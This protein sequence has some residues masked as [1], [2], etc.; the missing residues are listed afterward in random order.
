MDDLKDLDSVAEHFGFLHL[1]H[2]KD[3]YYSGQLPDGRFQKIELNPVGHPHTNEGPHV[4]IMEP[5]DAFSPVQKPGAGGKGN[6][7][8]TLA[9]FFVKGHE[10]YKKRWDGGS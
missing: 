9:Y 7:W 3:D 2:D 8:R 6:R 5:E 1:D 4:K 10:Q